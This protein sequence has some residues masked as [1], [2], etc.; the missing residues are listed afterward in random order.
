MARRLAKS[1]KYARVIGCDYS[2]TMLMEA[3]NRIRTDPVLREKVPSRT[4]LDLV[5][6]DVAKIPMQTASVDAL[7]SGAA[8][9]CWP[10]L[11]QG[12]SEIYRVLKPGG[13]FF[14]T[15]FITREL[16]IIEETEGGATDFRTQV[17]QNFE[18]AEQIKNYLTTAGFEEDKI[19]VEILG[20]AC[21]V[22]RCIK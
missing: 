8:M 6:C 19:E 16:G 14:A 13:R 21:I 15:T 10:E 5:R 12:L 11:Q 20:V 9:H 4:K 22:I 3:R 18:S 1:E 17:F 7:H 2:E